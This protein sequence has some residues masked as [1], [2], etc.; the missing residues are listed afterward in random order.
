MRFFKPG[1]SIPPP[2]DGDGVGGFFYITHME[3]LEEGCRR[4][5]PLES[6]P[7]SLK[8][9]Y[10]PTDELTKLRGLDLFCGGGNLGRGLEDGGGIEMKWANDWDAKAIHT[11]MAN[12]SSP[13]AVA[14][15]LGSIDDLQRLAIQGRFSQR[16][17]LI[18]EVDFI[19]GGSPC[20]GFSNLTNDKTTVTQRKNQSL[21]AAFA[22]FIDLYR[23][24][25]GL[26]ENVPG[27]VQKQASRNQDVFS[28]LICAV[29]GL[30]YQ[31]QFFFLDAS[32]CGSPQRRS[33]V[34][35]A[36]AAPGLCLPRSPSPTH[37]HP[38]NTRS[39]TLGNLPTG[40]PMAERAMPDATPFPFTSAY[41][42]T[43]D[44]PA[45]YDSKPNTCIPFP[46]HRVSLGLTKQLRTKINLIPTQPWGMNFAQTWFGQGREGP[47]KGVLTPAERLFFTEDT[48][49]SLCRTGIN[50]N[51]YGR[52]MPNR[53]I[54]TIVT[55]P[56][57]SDAKN[58]RTLHWQEG[59]TLSIM[60]ARRAQG[61]RD[62]DV[63]V[64][65][66]ADQ[67]RIVGNSVA[68]EVAVA[69]GV[70]FREAWVQ[71]LA[72]ERHDQA[73]VVI[74]MKSSEVHIAATSLP[75]PS[76]SDGT[77]QKFDGRSSDLSLAVEEAISS[78]NSA[79]Q[80]PANRITPDSTPPPSHFSREK[81]RSGSITVE[82]RAKKSLKTKRSESPG[83]TT[84][85]PSVHGGVVEPSPLGQAACVLD[86]D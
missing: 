2:Y 66:S 62:D 78:Q 77:T 48:G 51:A 1:E 84:R 52:Q 29:V 3:V 16:V 22:S 24:R 80:V 81:R 15:F 59:R 10:D 47:G 53:L 71:S 13:H 39:R 34:F 58:G 38:P 45:I 23:P 73:A 79:G 21:V 9:G 43:A 65:L 46:D 42:A 33:R 20:P 8:Q 7:T 6:F 70:V 40:E 69:L 64:G 74:E 60:E 56:S 85:Y 50:S 37:A 36:F 17:P 83:S 14:P 67:F 26:L 41:A 82:I 35:L 28:Q 5:L 63:L 19:S 49:S 86:S 11:Y 4:F 27:I 57:P 76:D 72:N 30:G 54:E 75:T 44:L 55:R 61:F 32:S 12:A 18:G 68:R 31:V 25:Y